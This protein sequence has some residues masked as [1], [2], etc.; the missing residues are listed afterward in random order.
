MLEASDAGQGL[1]LM[2][3]GGIDV[4]LVDLDLA[5]CAG[6]ELIRQVRAESTVPIVAIAEPEGVP[7][8]SA[9]TTT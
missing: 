3:R 6:L 9:R 8:G 2:R 1:A 4:M 7:A 5:D